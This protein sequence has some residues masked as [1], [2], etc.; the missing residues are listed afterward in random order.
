LEEMMPIYSFVC[1]SCNHQF[2]ELCK[3][4]TVAEKCP[5]CEET[6]QIRKTLSVPQT[7][8]INGSGPGDKWGYNKTTT[9]Y[10]FGGD[11]LRIAEQYDHKKRDAQI[12]EAK[13]K[14]EKK[15]ATVAVSKPNSKSK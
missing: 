6:S 5:N 3:I 12:K 13:K 1:D 9:E 11:G 2:D 4:N 8:K 10:M 14:A 7:P 15:G